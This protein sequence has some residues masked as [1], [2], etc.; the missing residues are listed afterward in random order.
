MTKNRINSTKEAAQ[1]KPKTD[2]G[3]NTS[4]LLKD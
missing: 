2:I 3:G 1:V 4:R